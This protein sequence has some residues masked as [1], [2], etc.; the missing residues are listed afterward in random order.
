MIVGRHFERARI[1]EVMASLRQGRGRT[2]VVSGDPGIGKSALLS[3]AAERAAGMQVLR[4][5]GV[6][7][8]RD[9]A[10]SGL[11][12]LLRPLLGELKLLP[13]RQADALRGALALGPAEAAERFAV[14]AATLALLA[15]AAE[16]KPVLALVDD[17]HWL[18]SG[19]T[20]AIYFAARR[21]T[22]A[23]V[24]LIFATRETVGGL[25]SIAGLE[26]LRLDGLEVEEAAELLEGVPL[27]RSV[28][29]ELVRATDGN[30]LALIEL[31]HVLDESV[32]R[33]EAPLPE[34]LPATPSIQRAYRRR[35]DGL[36]EDA[37]FAV[38]LTAAF[39]GGDLG[40]IKRALAA[41]GIEAGNALE[42][43]EAA[44]LISLHGSRYEF[45]HPLARSAL[46]ELA[47]PAERR[48]AHAALADALVGKEDSDR[49][50]WHLAEAA[51]GPDEAVASVVESSAERALAR[52]GFAA[53][54]VAHERAAELS[55][56][57]DQRARRLAAAAD[58]AQLAGAGE[59]ALRLLEQALETTADAVLRSE[60]QSARGFISF[61]RGDLDAAKQVFTE[62]ARIESAD[63]ARAAVIYA[64]LTGPCF[65]RG[66]PAGF[67][68]MAKRAR[69]LVEPTDAR[70]TFMGI[71]HWG[72]ALMYA[73]RMAEARPYLLQAGEIAERDPVALGDPVWAAVGAAMLSFVEEEDRARALFHRLIG[74]ARAT[75]SFGVLTF[76]LVALAGLERERGNWHRARAL[77]VE[78]VELSRDTGQ[79]TNLVNGL[80]E[81]ALLAGGQGREPECV[82]YA[83]EAL[84]LADAAGS[85]P[86][87]VYAREALALLFLGLGRAEQAIVELESVVLDVID[88][89]IGEPQV[90]AAVPELVEAYI[91]VGRVEEATNLLTHFE[92]LAFESRLASQLAAAARCR[93][94][95]ESND[96]EAAFRAGLSECDRVPRPFER[97]RIELCLGERLR[98]GRRRIDARPHLRNAVILF[99]QLGASSWAEKARSELR[100]SGE[101]IRRPDPRSRDTLTPQEL[102]VAL[103]VAEGLSNREAA[104]ALFLSPKTIEAHLGRVFRKL[105]VRSRSQLA[106]AFTG[107]AE[108][109]L[110]EL[111]AEQRTLAS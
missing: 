32:L 109:R 4:A 11:D 10:F 69:E 111:R 7:T 8:E 23:P 2:L 59:R 74:E 88:R 54:S 25:R 44:C 31:P 97:A 50:A 64:E 16:R 18:D 89:G 104:A 43:V 21:L 66:D 101:T 53:A 75:S 22:K 55:E 108:A 56:T 45:V 62:A 77:A 12:E 76:L 48:G 73:G 95:L 57:G 29:A 33:G 84:E 94:L 58:A 20:D 24:T 98:R 5:R 82:R 100:A 70:T 49:K 14:Q 1:E 41:R 81:C 80:N 93:G 92:R 61:W 91:R 99:E 13:P 6:E 78:C 85:L 42:A 35:C 40:P 15:T 26:E 86:D 87:T 79:S 47:Q 65:L 107:G 27:S 30:P 9:L 63:P 28:V 38:L 37:R 90:V 105:G 72:W 103:A 19:T 60:I 96:V 36:S 51:I 102:K 110:E 83:R 34:P 17:L 71:G 67:L 39:G 3:Y 52:G 68:E 46:Y 106:R